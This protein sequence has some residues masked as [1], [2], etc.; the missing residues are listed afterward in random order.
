MVCAECNA[1]CVI[2]N[3]TIIFHL[4]STVSPLSWCFRGAG[5]T[6]SEAQLELHCQEVAGYYWR[7]DVRG[8]E[9]YGN[10]AAMRKR[11]HVSLR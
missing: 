6:V 11:V 4:A 7:S 10:G 9:E 2:R 3:P 5:S 1:C 8:R